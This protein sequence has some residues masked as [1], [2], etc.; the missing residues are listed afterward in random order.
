MEAFASGDDLLRRI[1][2][3][4]RNHCTWDGFTE[5]YR[6]DL[7]AL[8]REGGAMSTHS[9][10]VLDHRHRPLTSL[11]GPESAS[12]RFGVDDVEGNRGT[13][14]ATPQSAECE[15]DEDRRAA[16]ADVDSIDGT[17]ST[18]RA[19]RNHLIQVSRWVVPPIHANVNAADRAPAD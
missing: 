1:T 2:P 15:P 11:Y 3:A 8:R 18:F 13:V 9:V 10:A 6:P 17:K 16:H 14:T 4:T 5:S 19:L 7:A 12:I